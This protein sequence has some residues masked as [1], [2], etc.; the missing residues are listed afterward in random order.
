MKVNGLKIGNIYY[1]SSCKRNSVK[2]VTLLEIIDS[3]HVK[4]MDKK[5]R[6]F[7]T[8]VSKLHTTPD[9]AVDGRKRK[10]SAMREMKRQR[11][12]M[13]RKEKESLVAKSIQKKIKKLKSKSYA[14]IENNVYVIIGYTRDLKFNSLD[15]MVAWIDAELELYTRFK[16]EIILKGYRLLKV[17][18]EDGTCDYFH[19]LSF[20]FQNRTIG[21]R[22]YEGNLEDFEKE[23]IL[24]WKYV[25]D[26]YQMKMFIRE[27]K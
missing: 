14:T 19:K 6:V 17:D 10:M 23:Q 11:E 5:N 20:D 1:L 16:E 18:N 21:C 22:K 24:E 3:K 25:F 4:L 9:K 27:E 8:N 26:T 13:I 15:E 2:L 12:S 7:T